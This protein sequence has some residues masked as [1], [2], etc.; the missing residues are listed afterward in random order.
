MRLYMRHMR[1]RGTVC[2]V[3]GLLLPRA[4]GMGMYVEICGDIP[5]MQVLGGMQSPSRHRPLALVLCDG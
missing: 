5:Y 2:E 4:C 3:G 1:G